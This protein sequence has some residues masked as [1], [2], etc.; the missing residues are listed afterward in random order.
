MSH[1]QEELSSLIPRFDP[2]GVVC[3]GVD[4]GGLDLEDVRRHGAIRLYAHVL[5]DDRRRESL[6]VG[7]RSADAATADK[8]QLRESQRLKMTTQRQRFKN[9]RAGWCLLTFQRSWHTAPHRGFWDSSGS[10]HNSSS[11]FLHLG[12]YGSLSHTRLRLVIGRVT[13]RR[14]VNALN[15]SWRTS[16]IPHLQITHRFCTLKTGPCQR[17][18][19]RGDRAGVWGSRR[20]S[21]WGK[22]LCR[23]NPTHVTGAFFSP[24][25]S[26]IKRFPTKP[27]GYFW[28]SRGDLSL[29]GP[30]DTTAQIQG[31]LYKACNW[32][33]GRGKT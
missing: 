12:S 20:G 7:V 9:T 24:E 1:P 28:H 16:C 31:S 2:E 4:V 29:T 14:R 6:A 26:T 3:V 30:P 25:N 22:T 33:R 8:R 27:Q 18:A 17:T 11:T 15:N 19:Q 23:S 32:P 5:V 10:P 21:V 13:E